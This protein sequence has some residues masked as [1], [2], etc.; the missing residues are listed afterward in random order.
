MGAA[1]LL[2]GLA[3]STDPASLTVVV[4]TGDDDEFYG[5]SVSPDLDTIVYTLAGLSSPETG[6]GV[7]GDRF[8]A[9][10]RL[11][12]L[13]GAPAWFR[14]GDRDLATHIFRSQRLGEGKRLSRVTAEICAALDVRTRVLPMSDDRIRTIVVTGRGELSFQEY[15]VRERARPRVKR[16]RFKGARLARPAPGVLGAI[17]EAATVVVAPSNP[18]VSIAPMLAVGGIKDA[19]ARARARV[20]AVSPLIGGRSVKGPLPAM[21]RSM[22]LGSGTAAIAEFYKGL[23]GRLIVA[24]GDLPRRRQPGWPE[25]LEHDTLIGNPERAERL[26]RFIAGLGPLGT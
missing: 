2:R 6:W 13:S 4:N 15:L 25:L 9:L 14:L 22:S 16:L 10:E 19:L 24:P 8:T 26:A 1:K 7:A 5:L 20:V 12:E 17:A 21:L 23:A 3:H 11:A 18:L